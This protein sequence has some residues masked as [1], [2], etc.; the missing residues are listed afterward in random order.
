MK[1]PLSVHA[2]KRAITF[3]WVLSGVLFAGELYKFNIDEFNGESFC[4]SAWSDNLQRAL[5]FTQ[6]EMVVKFVV[7]YAVPT[8]VMAVLYSLIVWCLW[9]RKAPGEFSNDNQRRMK[10]QMK[11]VITML[12][13]IVLIF[14]L[15]WIP[16][17]VNH[18]LIAFDLAA[19][20]KL[21]FPTTL[22]F[23]WLAHANSAINPCLY[24]IF[25]ESFRDGLKKVFR[26]C[27]GRKTR[28]EDRASILCTTITHASAVPTQNYSSPS[29]LRQKYNISHSSDETI[30]MNP[31]PRQQAGNEKLAMKKIK[32]GIRK[33]SLNEI[34]STSYCGL[35][36]R[37][38]HRSSDC[39][40]ALIGDTTL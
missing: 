32:S 20:H 36:P 31:V 6:Y 38:K 9:H 3:I 29:E 18:L 10:R 34:Q 7:A 28:F 26:R 11:K 13:T 5:L 40:A 12:L 14:N 15:C 35:S 22:V 4:G 30:P 39:S 19:Y 17:H 24:F 23:Y 2:V 25:N 21:P 8:S 33:I 27:Y 37:A 1:R 16:V